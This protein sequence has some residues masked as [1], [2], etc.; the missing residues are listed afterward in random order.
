[1]DLCIGRT[2]TPTGQLTMNS[3]SAYPPCESPPILLSS[4][5]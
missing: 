5:C 3:Y 1:L 4:I 2:V